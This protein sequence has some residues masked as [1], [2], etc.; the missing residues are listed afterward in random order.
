MHTWWDLNSQPGVHESDQVLQPLGQQAPL[1]SVATRSMFIGSHNKILLN[2]HE[3]NCTLSLS[4][5]LLHKLCLQ[6]CCNEQLLQ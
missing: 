4:T 2:K 6:Q 3:T 1:I 5:V